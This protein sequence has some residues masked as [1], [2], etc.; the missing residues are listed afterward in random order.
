MPC[1]SGHTDTFQ[2]LGVEEQL[3]PSEG[4]VGQCLGCGCGASGQRKALG[5]MHTELRVAWAAG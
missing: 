3:Q 1:P 5:S 4:A 2:P